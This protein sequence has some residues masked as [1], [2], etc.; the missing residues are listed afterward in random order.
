MPR[1]IGTIKRTSGIGGSD[2]GAICGLN[3]YKTAYQ[4]YLEKRGELP[5]QDIDTTRLRFGRR[6]E[7]P[8]ADEFAHITGRKLWRASQ[9][10]RHPEYKFLFANI[11]RWQERPLT[12]T[13]NGLTIPQR[14]ELGEFVERGVYE[15]KTADW[16]QRASWMQGGV[17]DSYYLQLQWYLLVTGCAF[18]SFGVL[19]GLSDFS[20][21]DVD[22][23]EATIQHLLQLAQDFWRRVKEG[24][25]PDYAYGQAGAA[26]C[27]RLY[28]KAE[29]KKT[30]VLSGP[31]V[32]AKVRRFLAVKAAIKDREAV[33]R[34]LE[35]W[36]KLQLGDAEVGIIPGVAKVTWGNSMRRSVDLN[37]LRLE[38][39]Q[40]ASDLTTETTSRRFSIINT[41]DEPIKPEE[42]EEQ[43]IVIT[44]GVRQIQID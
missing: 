40:I 26:L 6:L 28:A 44:T 9:T 31:E 5:E 30:I 11:D 10:I 7:K 25:P 16:R 39:P 32:E 41:S 12:L 21:F 29:P 35:T 15:G 42:P 36:L 14:P 27:K 2:I 4:L 38:H 24:N 22:R 19:F 18:G 20:Y 23:D 34:D 37:R 8:V 3:R 33:E 43:P 1:K 17:P 13:V